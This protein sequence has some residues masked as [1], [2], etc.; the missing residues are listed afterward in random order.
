[1]NDLPWALITVQRIRIEP[2]DALLRPYEA[3]LAVVL[4][5]ADPDLS[6]GMSSQTW[7]LAET[8]NVLFEDEPR[9]A[10]SDDG[11]FLTVGF[12]RCLAAVNRLSQASRL[13]MRE[14]DTHPLTKDS[15]DPYVAWFNV[16]PLTGELESEI[17]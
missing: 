1:M 14:I 15:L 9:E 6:S 3:G 11:E 8:V 2:R 7:V 12:E 5:E 16:D 17:R 10:A 13:L 4:G